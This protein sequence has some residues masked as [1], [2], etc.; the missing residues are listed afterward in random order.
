MKYRV[1]MVVRDTKWDG[2]YT[3]T[4]VRVSKST[5]FVQWHNCSVEDKLY[6]KDIVSAPDVENPPNNGFKPM[7]VRF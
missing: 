5:V 1:G 4:V 7:I 2:S 6:P 3:G